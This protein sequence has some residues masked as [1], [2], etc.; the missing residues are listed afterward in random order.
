MYVSL[1]KAFI[2]QGQTAPP[3]DFR[4]L[5]PNIQTYIQ[6]LAYAQYVQQHH[7]H[8]QQQ[9]Q[10]VDNNSYAQIVSNVNK[11]GNPYSANLPQLPA[12]LPQQQ[13]E[14]N[15]SRQNSPTS[16]KNEVVEKVENGT[17]STGKAVVMN[18]PLLSLATA[19]GMYIFC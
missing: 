17:E 18:K 14:N 7:Q 12:N 1:F 9:L 11:D 6:Q 8:Q 13:P 19:Y 16:I 3:T 2:I 15:V 4:S 5:D 10:Q